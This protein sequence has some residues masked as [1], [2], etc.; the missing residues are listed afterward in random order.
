M[1][2][3]LLKILKIKNKKMVKKY[4]LTFLTENELI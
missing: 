1:K 2:I 4:Y 3:I